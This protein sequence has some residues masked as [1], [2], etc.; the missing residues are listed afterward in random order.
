MAKSLVFVPLMSLKCMKSF[1]ELGTTDRCDFV[2]A[3]YIM[4]AVLHS[5][6]IVKAIMPVIVNEQPDGTHHEAFFQELLSGNVDGAPLPDVVSEKSR[7]DRF[8]RGGALLD[9]QG[10]RQKH[11]QLPGGSAP[12]P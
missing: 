2:L 12:F 5:R 1:T 3:E 4:A 8:D 10:H 11:A 7:A 6:G 9:H